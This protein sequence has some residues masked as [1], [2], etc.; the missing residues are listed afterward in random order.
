MIARFFIDRPIFAAVLSIVITLA[1]GVSISAL[2][3]ALYPPV[4]PPLVQVDC[5]YPGASAQVVAESVATPIEQQV[6]GVENMLYMSSQ[7]TNDGSYNLSV[8]FKHGVDLNMAQVLVQNRVSLAVPNLPDVIKQTG[9]TTRKKSP[10]IL[11]AVAI[12]SPD[13]RYDQ[14]YLSNYAL[15][16][17]KDELARLPGVSDVMMLGQR[18]YAMRIWLDPD[19]L[20]ARNL[21]AGDVTQAL[22]EQNAQVATGQIGQQPAPNGQ[23][24]QVPLSTLG[25][26]VDVEQFENVVLR[27]TPDARYIRIKDV[28]RVELGAK[29]QDMTCVV[30]GKQSVSM[31]IFQLPDA[32]ALDTADLVKAKINEL[33]KDFPDGLS[34]EVRYDTTPFIRES[35]FEV[36]KTLR[37]AIILVAVVV[38]LFLQNWRSAL[39]PLIAVPV[40]IIGT[41]AVM[42]AFGFSLNNL[43]LFGLVLAIGIVVDDAIVVVEAVEH[44]IEHGMTPRDATVRAMEEVSGPVIAIGL[45]LSAVFIPCA[46]ISGIVGQFFRQFALTIASSTIISAFNSLTLSPALAAL[47]LRAKSRDEKFAEPLPRIAF[48]LLGGWAV[49]AFAWPRVA[50]R[51]ARY[52]PLPA[53]FP[54]A[55]DSTRLV[56]LVLLGA[57]VGWMLGRPLNYLLGKFFAFFNAS[58]RLGTSAY[59]RVVG[60]LLRV[61]VLVL[62]AYGGLL[63]MTYDGFRKTPT[64]FIPSQ[65]MGYL[66]INVQLPDSA[67]AERTDRVMAKIAK[68]AKQIPGV[69]H[70]QT[71]GGMSFLLSANGSNFGSMFVILDDFANRHAPSMTGEAIQAEMRKRFTAEV[72]EAV[73]TVLGPPPV[74]GVGRAGGWKVMVEDRGDNGSEMIQGQTENLID[75]LKEDPRLT[76]PVSVFR[77]NVP[78]LFVKLNR[79]E[80]MTKEVGLKDFFDTLRIYCGSLYVNDFNRFGRTWQV[81]VQADARFRNTIENVKRLK[82]RNAEGMMVPLGTVADVEERNGPLVLMRYNM[83]PAAFINGS[84]APGVSSGTAIKLVDQKAKENLLSSMAIE[85]TELAFLE[86]QAGNTAMIVFGFAVVMVFLVLAAQYESWGLP[87]AVILVVPLCLLSG[88]VGVRLDKQDINVFTQIGFVVLVGLASKNAI[89]IVE[90]AKQRREAGETGRQATLDACRLRL[91]PIVMTSLAFI[92]GVIPLI[93]GHGAGS[94]M[95]HTLGITVFSGMLGVTVFGI[96]LTPV[97]FYVIDWLGETQLFAS[98]RVRFAGKIALYVLTLGIVPLFYILPVTILRELRKRPAAPGKKP[99]PEPEL[100]EPHELVEQK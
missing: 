8:T 1:G 82:V 55:P 89:L 86:L 27:V 11:M 58:F 30:N 92:L 2:P 4:S 3:L 12:N 68:I 59:T 33:A 31:A 66:L 56:A 51:I 57:A 24:I 94:E 95:R 50:E 20:A 74:R 21:T 43:T 78:Q 7:C 64:G 84:T 88:V 71:M 25:R 14:L 47:L 42:A 13:G 17:M 70:T 60:G 72:P 44:H 62:L 9:V 61:S 29:N 18:D 41:F 32:N 45:V 28:G 63:Y 79:I 80:S 38:L 99:A 97:F 15:L 96:F 91:R 46:F 49:Y 87:L 76:T 48:A 10:D 53:T 5:N 65:D 93:V 69:K 6:N 81:I 37:D 34:W 22:R 16:H 19:K 36:F 77:A 52:M 39:I 73:L 54:L 67:S 26:L 75:R 35:I 23:A 100:P 90:F 83:Y 40:A 85:W 98:K